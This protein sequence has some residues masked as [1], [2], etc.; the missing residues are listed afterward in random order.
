MAAVAKWFQW[1]GA[2]RL[3]VVAL[4]VRADSFEHL[5]D[6]T[7]TTQSIALIPDSKS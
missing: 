3:L 5:E 6:Q 7:H 2:N 4:D 1:L